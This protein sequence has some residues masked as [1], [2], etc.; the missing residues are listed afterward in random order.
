[1]GYDSCGGLQPGNWLFS[2]LI[3]ELGDV[4]YTLRTAATMKRNL[5]VAQATVM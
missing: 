2:T 4:C 5:H 1:M 3:L